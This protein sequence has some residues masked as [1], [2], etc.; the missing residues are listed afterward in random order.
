MGLPTAARVDQRV[1]KKFLLEHGNPN[2][3]DKKHIAEDVDALLW[4]AALKPEAIGVPA[5]N[6]EVR[7]YG[8]IAVL[9]V[10]LRSG[11]NA[12]R[13]AEYI[14]RAI[15]YPAIL[16]TDVEGFVGLSVAHKRRA[17]NEPGR[18]VLD[19]DV[20]EARFD[21]RGAGSDSVGE[22]V[23]A[24]LRIDQHARSNL[25][26]TYRGIVDVVV[27]ARAFRVTRTFALSRSAEHSAERRLA[28]DECERLEREIELLLSRAARERQ[29]ARQVELN[30][31]VKRLRDALT[32][33]RTKL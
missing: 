2:A 15:P 1:P 32:E 13:I 25:W 27:A 31:A 33:A 29:L 24:A 20:I 21:D 23:L 10:V 26:E 28:L 11:T 6:D 7:E 18:V 12:T 9:H 19:G 8:E 5:T 14:H 30:L 4:V 16:V 3:T 17:Q 22:P